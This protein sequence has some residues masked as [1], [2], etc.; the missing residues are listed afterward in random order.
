M[1]KLV[2]GFLISIAVLVGN[3]P[4]VLIIMLT[5]CEPYKSSSGAFIPI[6]IFIL[7]VL[8]ITYQFKLPDMFMRVAYAFFGDDDNEN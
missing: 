8:W 6:A 5:C 3:I 1:R 4:I 2:F 7:V